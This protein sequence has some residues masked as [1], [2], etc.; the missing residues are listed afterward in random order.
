MMLI[1]SLAAQLKFTLIPILFCVNAVP[2][3]SLLPAK[4]QN[5]GVL[6]LQHQLTDK[7]PSQTEAA[8][9]K[10]GRGQAPGRRR[11][12][13]RRDAC[14]KV[15]IPLTAIVPQS[16][17]T[18]QNPPVPYVGSLTTA[19]HP[20]FWFYVPY[21]LNTDLTAEFILQDEAGTEIYKRSSINFTSV[22]HTPGI[23]SISLPATV[24]LEIGKR[25]EWY[26]KVS[27]GLEIPIYA[28]G[29]IERISPDDSLSRQL[30]NATPQEQAKLYQENGIWYDAVTVLGNLK[31]AHPND[32]ATTAAWNQLLQVLGIG[33]ILTAPASR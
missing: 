12:G 7:A 8:N 1:K 20:T 14:P 13:G 24:S 5:N 15:Q 11:G 18:N 21:S 26:F 30:A 17:D 3:V 29:G 23:I 4:A 25:Y 31:R 27:C 19:E 9:L 32:A 2:L 28:N 10:Q 22:E 33:D 16:E 6:T